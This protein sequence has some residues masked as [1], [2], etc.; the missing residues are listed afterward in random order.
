MCSGMKRILPA[1]LLA[2]ACGA[3]PSPVRDASAEGVAS[4]L[5]VP[6]SDGPVSLVVDFAVEN[7]PDFDPVSFTCTG[8]VPLAVRFVPLA[9]TTVTKYWWDFGDGSERSTEMA[10]SHVYDTPHVYTVTIIATGTSGGLVTKSHTGFVVA[11]ANDI[12]DPCATSA[13]CAPDCFCLCP[14]GTGCTGG[15]ARGMCTAECTADTAASPCAED[16]VCAGLATTTPLPQAPEP[17]Q[18][19]LCLPAC[20]TDAD[21]TAGL[22][23]RTLPPGPAGIAWVRGCFADSPRDIGDSCTDGNGNRRDDLCASG[24]CADLG[25]LG[26]CTADCQLASC[27]PGSD[28]AALGDGRRLCLRP[29]VGS[30]TCAQDP[31]LPCVQPGPGALGYQILG[32]NNN[33]P[34]ASTYCAPRACNSDAECMPTGACDDAAGGGHCVRR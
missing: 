26:M 9:T 16:Q 12:G 15:P 28:C 25:T 22:R 6:S 32:S 4:D 31:L 34:T 29:C 8:K 1:V 23:C 17:W 11:K 27:P 18:T 30:F 10:P 33:A 14:P 24:M 19:S 5:P 7:C 13:Q 20:T 2:A 21:C 3:N